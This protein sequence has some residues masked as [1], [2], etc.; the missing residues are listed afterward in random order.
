MQQP[1]ACRPG[2]RRLRRRARPRLPS[3]GRAR[4]RGRQALLSAGA[5]AFSPAAPAAAGAKVV[6]VWWPPLPAERA[7]PGGAA[8]GAAG[9]APPL[10]EAPGFSA[11]T[12]R[13]LR[14][15]SPTR[16]PRK[17]SPRAASPRA[18]A[19][20]AGGGGADGGRADVA[21]EEL[22]HPAPVV[23]LQWSPG[24]LQTGAAPPRPRPAPRARARG[25]LLS[26]VFW[27]SWVGTPALIGKH[28]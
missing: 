25:P 5:H 19:P 6:T 1:R 23:S 20:A 3:D 4:A 18:G 8:P 28:S 10:A 26:G 13:L 12:R 14:K 17:G 21:A 9:P 27:S 2:S 7:A 16:S 24:V 15:L 22:R 11:E